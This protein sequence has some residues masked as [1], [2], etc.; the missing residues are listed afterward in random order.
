MLPD[1]EKMGAFYLGKEDDELL[2]YDSRHLLTH[3]VVIGM[4]GSGKTGLSITILEEAALDGV[5]AIVI[6]PKGDLSN[7]LL[8]FPE[9][10]AE[11]FAPWVPEGKDPQV[12]ADIWKAGLAE[13]GQDGARIARLR[14]AVDIKLYTPGSKAGTPVSFIKSLELPP[15]AVLEDEEVL[16]ERIVAVVSS[17]LGL[18]GADADPVKSREHVLLSRIV[19][20]TWNAGKS[21]DLGLLIQRIQDPRV[22]KIGVLDLESFFP[23]KARFE[24]A[25]TFNNLLASPG[26]ATWLEGDAMDIDMFLRAPGVDGKGKPRISIFSI[27]HLGDQERMFFVTLLLHQMVGWMR[28]QSGTTSLRALFYMDEIFGFFPPVANPPSKMPLLTLLKQARAF[29]LGVLLATQNPV[30]LDYKG[31]SN[32]GTW[33]IGRLQTERDKARVVEGLLSASGSRPVDQSGLD[34]LLSSLEKRQFLLHDVHDPEGPRLLRTRFT[35]SY[36]RGPLTRE[37]L[38]G[39]KQGRPKEALTSPVA[40]SARTTTSEAS[41]IPVV[42]NEITQVFLGEGP[43][44]PCLLGVADITISDTKAGIDV[45]RTASFLIPFR[46]GALPVDWEAA[47]FYAGDVASLPSRASDE[48]RAEALPDVA[49]KAKSYAVW[50]KEFSAWLF[51]NQGVSRFKSPGSGLLSEPNE[52]ESAFRARIELAAREARDRALDALRAKYD[53]KFA[54]LKEKIRTES[55]ALEEATA[56]EKAQV[57]ANTFAIGASLVGAIFGRTSVTKIARGVS[58]AA[59]AK[60]QSEKA[61]ERTERRQENIEALQEKW[62]TLDA[63][64]QEEAQTLA[65]KFDAANEA[66]DRVTAKPKKAGIRVKLFALA[67]NTPSAE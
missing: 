8:T 34:R 65:Q 40:T 49:L 17:L 67:W 7:L 35:L 59:R 28:S 42:A 58:Q 54:Q 12:E 55:Q 52:T 27:A 18:V 56:A 46:E 24:L 10:R 36:L 53:P 13:W 4:T 3:G 63:T 22:S 51:A 38:K 47:Q 66:L 37:Q 20:D 21:L 6:D 33:F 62:R 64:F 2:M 9:L 15:A 61:S 41:A 26:F 11:D 29:G 31:L 16:R 19:H 48:A 50:T 30:D 45:A 23:E 32:A 44:V 43:Y 5:P 14:E 25:S 60:G 57:Q 39:F 1:Y